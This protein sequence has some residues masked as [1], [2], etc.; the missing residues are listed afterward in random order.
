MVGFEP[1]CRGMSIIRSNTDLSFNPVCCSDGEDR[2]N[3]MVAC[4]QDELDLDDKE[5]PLPQPNPLNPREN[6]SGDEGDAEP[7][8]AV[9]PDEDLDSDA[10]LTV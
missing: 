3:P 4:D 7:A 10:E 9:M 2:G 6:L 8:P 1:A 5:P